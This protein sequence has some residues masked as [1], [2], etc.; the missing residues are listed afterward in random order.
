MFSVRGMGVADRVS[1]STCTADLLEPLLV[2]DAEA[3]LLVHD[4]QAQILELHV[5]L[6]QPVG[7]DEHVD[8]SR[9][10]GRPGSASA[11]C[12]CW[13]RLTTAISHR[14]ALQTGAVA[15]W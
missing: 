5:L 15:V 11:A 12:R 2:G 3:L 13:N 10:A 6:Q 1:T 7:A 14:V 8:R 9:S 4:Q